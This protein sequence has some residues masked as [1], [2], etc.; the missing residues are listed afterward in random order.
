MDNPLT[1][2]LKKDLE[3]FTISKISEK[4]KVPHGTLYNF[5]TGRNT[6]NLSN[7]NKVRSAVDD[8]AKEILGES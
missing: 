7:F 5:A 2:K 1:T 6:L 3:Y 8:I 4:S